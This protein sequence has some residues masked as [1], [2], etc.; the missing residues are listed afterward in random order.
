MAEFNLGRIRFVWKGLW[1]ASTVYVKDDIVR[2]GGKTY[3]CVIGHTSD[4]DF[5]IDL[6]NIPT[7]WNQMSDGQEWKGA[8]TTSTNY[9]VNDIVKYGGY[10]YICNTGHQSAATTTLGLEDDQGSWDLF[11]ETFDWKTDW[12]I[13]TRY[14][15]NDIVKY[16]GITY[17]CNQ[18]HTSAA[19]I[20][21]GLEAD[22]GKWD[23]LHKGIE[24]LGSWSGASVRYKINDI[25]KYGAGLWIC[26]TYHTSSATFAESNW[27]QFVEGLEFNDTWNSSAVYQPGDTVAYGGYVYISKTNNT[28]Q[29]PT[30]NSDDWD[31]YITGFKFQGP[32]GIPNFYEVGNVVRF[33]GYIYLA[34]EDHE[35]SVI[36]QPPNASY[37]AQLNS[38]QRWTGQWQ[39]SASY[40]LG[41]LVKFG[42]S[43]YI[44]IAPH[45]SSVPNRPDNDTL[46]TYWNI[47]TSGFELAVLTTQGDIAYYGGAGPTR[48]P[49]G[50]EGM[51]LKVNSNDYPSWGYF[52]VINQVFYVAPSGDD[53]PNPLNGITIDRP[54]KTVQYAL[55]RIERGPLNPNSRWLL[56]INRQ[57]VQKEVTGWIAAQIAGSIAPFTGAFTYDSIK[58]ERDIGLIVDALAYDL[59]HGGNTAIRRAAISYGSEAATFY[60]LGQ[61]EETIAAINY[62]RT[63]IDAVLSN[64]APGTVYQGT[65]TQVIDT[66]YAEETGAQTIVNN[67]VTALT[68]AINSV[69]DSATV[70]AEV[71]TNYTLSVKTGTFNEVLPMVVPKD[72]A[73]VGDEL[74][75][76]RIEPAGSLVAVGDVTYSMAALV[77]LSSIVSNIIQNNAVVKST[78]NPLNPNTTRPAG[79]S[80]AGTSAATLFTAAKNYIDFYVNAVGTAPAMT[81]TNY[82]SLDENVYNAINV[83][84]IN[85]EFLAEEAV[86]YINV[87]YP[88]YA[89]T[90]DETACKRDVREYVDAIKWDLVY[91]SNYRTLTAAKLYVN[92]VNGSELIDMFYLRSGTG[93]RNCTLAGL[94]GVLQGPNQYGTFRPTAGAYTSLDP[95]WGPDDER[96]WITERSP[97]VQNVTTFGTACVGLKV[98]GDLHNGG[99][100]SIVANDYTQVLSDGIGAWVTNLGRAELVSVFSYYAHIAYLAEDGGKIRATNGNNSYGT[101]GSVSEGVDATEL[102]IAGKVNNKSVEAQIGLAF[103]DGLNNI[104][105]LEYTN[106][107]ID[108]N[109]ATYTLS[110]T[111]LN[112]AAVADEFRDDG[113]FEVRL[114]DPGDS[115]GI[116]GDGYVFASNAAQAGS[117]GQI[118]I[119]NTDTATSSAYVGMHIVLNA[120]TGAGQEAVILNYN[121]GTKVALIYKQSFTTL[122]I[123]DTTVTSNLITVASTGSLY[124]NMPIYVGSNVGGLTANTL[125]YVRAGFT[126]TQFT[127]STSPGGSAVTLST[128]T[129]QT[130]P[131]Y[132][133]GW[134]STVRGRTIT[135]ALDVTTS[136][137]IEPRLSFTSPSFSQTALTPGS[138]GA[139]SYRQIEY[140]DTINTYTSV[141]ASGGS[142]TGAIFT[143]VRQGNYYSTLTCTTPGS[144][145]QKDDVLTILGTSVGGATPTNDITITVTKVTGGG[146]IAFDHTGYA[147]GGT[148]VITFTDGNTRISRNNGTSWSAGGS[149]FTNPVIGYGNG[150]WVAVQQSSGTA[151][152]VSTDGSTWAA[153]GNLPA[154]ASWYSVKYGN[155]RWIAISSPLV[156][157]AWSTDNG[158]SWNAMGALPGSTIWT[159]IAYGA[160]VWV[161]ISFNSTQAA[162]SANGTTW[163]SRTLPA[164][165]SWQSVTF[166]NGRFV[167]T[168]TS[169]QFGAYSLDG[170]TWTEMQ[171]P[172]TGNWTKVAYGQ[173]IFVA[174]STASPFTDVATSEDGINWTLRSVT[175]ASAGYAWVAFGNNDR[176]GEFILTENSTAGVAKKL[177]T[178]ATTRARAVVV[179]EKITSIR[180]VEPGSGYNSAPTMTI[181]DPNNITE[182][183]FTVRKGK[184]IL[185]NPTF[186]NRGS[187][188]VTAAATVIGSGYADL[189]QT[190]TFIAFK[191]LTDIPKAGSNVRITGINDLVYKLVGVTGLTQQGDYYSAT[192]QLSPGFGAAES[193]DHEESAEIRIRYSQV[194]LTGHD[195]LDIGTGNFISTNYPGLP[196]IDPDPTKETNEFGG[197]RVFYTSTDQ[198]GNFRVGDIFS[199]EQSTGVATLNADAFSIAGLQELQLGSVALGGSGATISE[200]STDPFF[201]ADSDNIVPT[202]RAIK[203]YIN[204]QIGSGSSALNVNSLTAGIVFIAGDTITTTTGAQININTKM[205]FNSGV[206]GYFL[207]HTLF[208]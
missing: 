14:K 192:L 189:Y 28:N 140:G 23:F 194:R 49:I 174:T 147:Q 207:A 203:A 141:S 134:D 68:G 56:E 42:P 110:G 122:T 195:F 84:E 39:L 149:I 179:D 155:G 93:V 127:V 154:T 40:V 107:G 64:V 108:Y 97:Y 173:G 126:T 3:L 91:N 79:S 81:G 153:G 37:W 187:S 60:L 166:G 201:T 118:T 184:G 21:L 170:I 123:T 193:P 25:V 171:L 152:R 199:V 105:R 6:T 75:S 96:G 66:N 69:D 119:A 151:T 206:D 1:S 117:V 34:I 103:T 182:A 112:A 27:S 76:T 157:S 26:T 100:D 99:N 57:F 85:K 131:L 172:K 83:L 13:S 74:R 164:I 18:H 90:Y 161:A 121:S 50:E 133:A 186:T 87:T 145:Y 48:L 15:V 53:N 32:W 35:A 45:T 129:S 43:S 116:G 204:S 196:L 59:A 115:S 22:Q 16:G 80:G 200:F 190:G 176:V 9:K 167:A 130:V 63:V 168:A 106:A 55:Q 20:S 102:P 114:T 178:G 88:A 38:G 41:D 188:Y 73:V 124:Q 47:F 51:V 165:R 177:D 95:G 185:A 150:Y 31:L 160:G 181:T 143:V 138:P 132:A 70:F 148:W 7:R 77:R 202:Q 10:I 159:D 208:N 104:L 17:I 58:C 29:V 5:N 111:G 144:G 175:G 169:T 197:G 89:G 94:T 128:T 72:T 86:A 109:S 24:Y 2:Y 11:A 98:D 183:S 12:A 71:K 52:G 61:K 30:S 180:I 54:W 65:V 120:G 139:A 78:G 67:L 163:T 46:G 33:S 135:D 191:R 92:A 36:N 125:Y 137:Q 8:W 136:Y 113:T 158:A 4:A 205:N 82:W 146:V 162:S 19:T 44:C 62:A 101:Y 156:N 142:G 198:D